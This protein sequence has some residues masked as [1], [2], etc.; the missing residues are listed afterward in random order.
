MKILI[1]EANNA[2]LQFREIINKSYIFNEEL[3]KIL[4]I[5]KIKLLK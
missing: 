3:K 5:L 2:N 1:N 4:L